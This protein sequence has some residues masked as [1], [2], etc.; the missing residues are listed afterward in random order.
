VT[1]VISLLVSCYLAFS[2]FQFA[3]GRAQGRRRKS[4]LIS[5]LGR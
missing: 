2:V 4:N 3:V 1:A 5:L